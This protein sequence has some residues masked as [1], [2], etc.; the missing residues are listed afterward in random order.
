M[1]HPIVW[2]SR[3]FILSHN[4]HFRWQTVI[5]KDCVWDFLT[6]IMTPTLYT[7]Q[8]QGFIIP[9]LGISLTVLYWNASKTEPETTKRN[10]LRKTPESQCGRPWS[11]ASARL[12]QRFALV[13]KE[14]FFCKGNDLTL[15]NKNFYIHCRS[16]MLGSRH[17]KTNSTRKAFTPLL[18]LS[19]PD[20]SLCLIRTCYEMGWLILLPN[21]GTTEIRLNL[22]RLRL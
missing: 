13:R 18:T 7:Q 1:H 8:E 21:S 12:T 5:C 15:V 17:Q 6:M 2:L 22:I 16:Q 9:N 10:S 14:N 19:F 3:T 20:P 11:R 4:V